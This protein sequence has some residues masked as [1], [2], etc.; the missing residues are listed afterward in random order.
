MGILSEIGAVIGLGRKA[1][2]IDRAALKAGLAN[3]TVALVDVREAGEFA[4]G[5]VPGATNM[6]MSAFKVDQLPNDGRKVV[7]MCHTGARARMAAVRAADR[8][9]PGVAVYNGSMVDWTRAGETVE[10]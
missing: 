4:S 8:G 7:V 5:H 6:P 10:K 2:A 1:E 9:R 3:G